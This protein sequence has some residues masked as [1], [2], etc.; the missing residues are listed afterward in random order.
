[1]P[2]LELR[3]LQPEHA[4]IVFALVTAQREHLR[5]WLPWVDGTRTVAD[6]RAFLLDV[7]VKRAAGQ[8]LAYGIW[9]DATLRGVLG[10]H[11]ISLSNGNLQVG[12]WLSQEAE[13]RGLMT[14]SVTAMLA[15]AYDTL[16]MER[17][18]IRCAVRN[19]RSWAIPERLGF[20]LEGVMRHFQRLH[21]EF[22]DMRL[23]SMLEREYRE[24]FSR[25]ESAQD[26]E[27]GL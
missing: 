11:D 4:D 27:G 24:R 26:V 23:Y 8:T 7:C 21:G 13:G 5:V 25:R 1:M 16:R 6:T 9:E 15:V 20:S 10:F 22:V 19:R 3:A 17:V 18:E 2:G 12:Y 14:M